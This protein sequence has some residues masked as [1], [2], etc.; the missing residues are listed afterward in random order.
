VA[1]PGFDLREYPE[2]R[3]L[4]FMAR[5]LIESFSFFE[6]GKESDSLKIVKNG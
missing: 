5:K 4:K 1:K 6:A 3:Y 2:A